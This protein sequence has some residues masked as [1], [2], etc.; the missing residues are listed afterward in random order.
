MSVSATLNDLHYEDGVFYP[1]GDGLPMAETPIHVKAMFWMMQ[2]L[3]T[4][5]RPR[6]DDAYIGVDMF[7]YW[8][9]GNPRACCAPDVFAAFGVTDP[10]ADRNSFMSWRENGSIPAVI[11][12]MASR[13]TWKEN[14]TSKRDK[15]RQLKVK[16]YFIFDPN[17]QF[18]DSQ[19]I[20]YRLV[21]GR[22]RR[23][24]ADREGRWE[25]QQLGV[26]LVPEGPMLRLVDPETDLPV[27]TEKERAEAAK[28]GQMALKE[29]AESAEAGQAAL[30]KENARLRALLRNQ[31][32]PPK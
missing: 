28:A 20:G 12:E 26:W 21:N 4:W 19:V 1:S 27:L 22:Y 8:E 6:R 7:W 2:A 11:F 5:L 25:S 32:S 10:E 31:K 23:V 30:A 29:R 3:E 18:L 14:L 24:V 17:W 9:K 15:Y 16:E 13:K